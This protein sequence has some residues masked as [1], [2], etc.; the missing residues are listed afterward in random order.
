MAAPP[1]RGRRFARRALVGVGIGTGAALGGAGALSAWRQIALPRMRAPVAAT[2]AR[3]PLVAP[4]TYAAIGASDA[5]GVGVADPGRDGWVS[6]FARRLPAGTRLVNLGVPGI[7]LHRA[8]DTVL[9][10][11]ISAQPG[12][13]TVWLVVNDVLAGVSLDS[14]RADLDRLLRELRAGTAA[15]IAVGNLPD[16]PGTVGGVQLPQ[17][18]RRTIVAQWN[19]AIAGVV[20]THDAILVDLYQRWPV[21]QHPEFLG[22]DGLHPTASGYQSLAEAFATTLTAERLLLG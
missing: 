13:V 12:L 10:R 16:P 9:P 4:L 21:G 2:P 14:Y 8:L 7:T 3:P 15:Q 19:T 17:F 5:A 22:A 18:V 1:D 6:I 20:R 11:A